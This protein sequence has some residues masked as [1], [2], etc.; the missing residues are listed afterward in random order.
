M[1][2]T[3]INIKYTVYQIS[4]SLQQ[5]HVRLSTLLAR[6]NHLHIHIISLKGEVWAHKTR[7]PPPLFIEVH[8]PSQWSCIFMLEY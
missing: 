6:G 3:Q 7:L 1:L 8:V 2:N 4:D 5:M